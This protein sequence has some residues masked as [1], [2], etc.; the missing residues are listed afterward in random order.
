MGREVKLGILRRM[1]RFSP[2]FLS[3]LKRLAELTNRTQTAAIE[4]AVNEKLAKL[5]KEVKCQ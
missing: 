3:N 5:K 2:A 4:D 1:Y